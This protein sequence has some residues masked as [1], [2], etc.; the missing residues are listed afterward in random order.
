V[1]QPRTQNLT[2]FAR[3]GHASGLRVLVNSPD[4]LLGEFLR[5]GLSEPDFKVVTCLP[6]PS[7][8]AVA[9]REHPEIAVIDRVNDRP[10]TAA[11]EIL[12]LKEIRP[13]V[14]IIALSGSSSPQD[15]RIVEHGIFFY[16]ATPTGA[17]VIQVIEAAAKT[18][19]RSAQEQHRGAVPQPASPGATGRSA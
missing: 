3:N 19:Y 16:M 10:D 15:A 11:M 5:K 1:N 18:F 9:Y 2:A 13:N 4:G 7:F 6:G 12:V 8:M 17:E 14:R